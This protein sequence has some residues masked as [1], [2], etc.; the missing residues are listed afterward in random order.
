[1]VAESFQAEL[2]PA[3]SAPAVA[4]AAEKEVDAAEEP[5]SESVSETEKAG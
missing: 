2:I 4:P 1:L 3:E 5:A